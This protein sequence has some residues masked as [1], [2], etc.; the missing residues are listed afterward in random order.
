VAEL[1][2]ARGSRFKPYPPKH[3]TLDVPAAAPISLQ[4]L[5]RAVVRGISDSCRQLLHGPIRNIG[6]QSL[7]KWA[8]LLGDAKNPKRWPTVFRQPVDLY[9]AL[10]SVFVFIEIGG[11]GGSAFRS[12]YAAFLSEAAGVLKQ[13]RL[14]EV[15]RVYGDCARL[16]SEV[17]CAA[18]PGWAPELRETREL[19]A[20][21][22]RIF[23]EQP[24]GARQQMVKTGER[25]DAIVKGA[26]K[27]FP[28]PPGSVPELLKGLR[29]SVL[30]VHAAEMKAVT[31]LEECIR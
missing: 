22:N 19:L 30:C 24:T 20:R 1:A 31:A 12:M 2:A 27:R 13:P 15:A 4:T 18:L 3:K 8:A 26:K 9:G 17:A 11:T 29:E 21:K 14:E 23:D 5:E 7:L 6:L 16:W 10:I 25:L 28:A